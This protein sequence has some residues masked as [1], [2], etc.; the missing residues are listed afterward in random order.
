M[1]PWFLVKGQF[2]IES[3]FIDTDLPDNYTI[4]PTPNGWTDEIISFAWLQVFDEFTS[5]RIQKG[6]YRL[7]LMDNHSSHLTYNFIE[8]Y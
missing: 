6:K 5:L 3:W 1:P 4:C 7:L 8:F 2:Y